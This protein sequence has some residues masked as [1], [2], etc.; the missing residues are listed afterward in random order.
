MSPVVTRVVPA[1]LS[2]EFR[3]ETLRFTSDPCFINC[4][5]VLDP[6]VNTPLCFMEQRPELHMYNLYQNTIFV[7]CLFGFTPPKRGPTG[8]YELSYERTA[9][10]D[11]T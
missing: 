4:K 3:P 6:C 10:N 8:L 1:A 9:F 5:D 7:A 2:K 11:I